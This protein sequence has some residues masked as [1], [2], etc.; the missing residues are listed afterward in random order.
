M[1]IVHDFISLIYPRICCGCGIT[2]M[3]REAV[4]CT[5]CL[6]HLP[7]TGFHLDDDN[8]VSRM[9]WGRAHI[10]MAASFLYFH[11]GSRVQHLI[12]QLKYKS[13]TEIGIRLGELYG[14]ELIKSPLFAG[15]SVIIP[16]PLHPRKKRKRGY[17]QS[18]VIARGISSVLKVPVDTKSL[19]RKTYTETQTRKTRFKRWENVKEVF[20]INNPG[21][22]RGKHILLVDDVITTGATLEACA[23]R[24]L[25]AEGTR[26]SIAS[27]ACALK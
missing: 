19:I 18:E 13:K 17:N 2:L 6:H 5:W 14:H 10:E 16:V 20:V 22:I 23:N 4:I 27:V 15:I 25:E 11:K 9:F 24:V 3:R 21:Q 1:S 7:R 8:P 12:H 26:V